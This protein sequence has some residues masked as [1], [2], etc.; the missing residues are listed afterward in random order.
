M[1]RI[2]NIQAGERHGGD[3]TSRKHHA[4]RSDR[5]VRNDHSHR[6]DGVYPSNG[7]SVDHDQ[8]GREY[9]LASHEAVVMLPGLALA[10]WATAASAPPVITSLN[11]TLGDIAGGGQPTVIT[12]TTLSGST[13]VLI[14][15]NNVDATSSTSTT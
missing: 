9:H 13:N 8:V 14:G 1:G 2:G 7:C 6:D 15:R 12:G 4:P 10:I 3:G 11:Y 5:M